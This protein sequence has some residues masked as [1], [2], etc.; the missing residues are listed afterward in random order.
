MTGSVWLF[1]MDELPVGGISS[2]RIP[3]I[4]ELYLRAR[5]YGSPVQEIRISAAGD[6]YL[7][8]ILIV[9][10]L[11]RHLPPLA[12]CRVSF[13]RGAMPPTGMY[14][15]YRVVGNPPHGRIARD[16]PAEGQGKCT[17]CYRC[18]NKNQRNIVLV[19]RQ[20]YPINLETRNFVKLF[21][22]LFWFYDELY[23]LKRRFNYKPVYAKNLYNNLVGG[24]KLC[25]V[26]AGMPHI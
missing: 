10:G 6:T 9:N 13:P 24:G 17:A 18:K 25:F 15:K 20:M 26:A 4:R 2:N 14:G 8:K 1:S 19:T 5:R 11:W 3:G 12:R 23:G 22:R 7:R 16:T 21:W